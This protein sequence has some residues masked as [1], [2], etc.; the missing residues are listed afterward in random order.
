MALKKQILS[1]AVVS[2]VDLVGRST[3]VGFSIS[4]ADLV[5]KI[6]DLVSVRE[7]SPSSDLSPIAKLDLAAP[8]IRDALAAVD[9]LKNAYVAESSA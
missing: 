6:F 7:I 1:D 9:T 2:A 8:H 3:G 5:Q 4:L